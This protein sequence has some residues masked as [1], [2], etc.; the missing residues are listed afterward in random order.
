MELM[1]E[2]VNQSIELTAVEEQLIKQARKALE[3]I[4][5]Y[6]AGHAVAALIYVN[7]RPIGIDFK[8]SIPGTTGQA[9]IAPTP[10]PD[11]APEMFDGEKLAP[12]FHKKLKGWVKSYEEYWRDCQMEYKNKEGRSL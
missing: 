10:R 1:V 5:F 4:N 11:L 6:P 12:A 2:L 8:A 7:S 3:P 9:F